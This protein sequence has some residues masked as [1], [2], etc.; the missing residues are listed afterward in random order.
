MYRAAAA[1]MHS[2]S[3]AITLNG[4][5]HKTSRKNCGDRSYDQ[6]DP[7]RVMRLVS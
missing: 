2:E 6:D 4:E 3:R 7:G 1:G 5:K